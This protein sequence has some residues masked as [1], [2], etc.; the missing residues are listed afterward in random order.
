[1]TQQIGK[2]N[3]SGP[4]A[5]RRDGTIDPSGYLKSRLSDR[6]NLASHAVLLIGWGVI[7]SVRGGN[8][9]VF[10]LVMIASLLIAEFGVAYAFRAVAR[11]REQRRRRTGLSPSW[12]AALNAVLQAREAGFSLPS[13]Y[14]NDA[15]VSGRLSND[16]DQWVWTAAS[17]RRRSDRAALVFDGGWTPLPSERVGDSFRRHIH[18]C[19]DSTR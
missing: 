2:H 13:S 17:N 16:A 12:A 15:V 11:R 9:A 19:R 3:A 1:M 7:W 10:V 18:R 5:R 6:R 4:T 14:P 8:G